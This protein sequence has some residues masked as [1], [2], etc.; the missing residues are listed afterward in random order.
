MPLVMRTEGLDLVV[1]HANQR[2]ANLTTLLDEVRANAF[3]LSPPPSKLR[4]DEDTYRRAMFIELWMMIAPEGRENEWRLFF[5]A[6]P[7]ILLT[8]S[9]VDDFVSKYYSETQ[10]QQSQGTHPEALDSLNASLEK[11]ALEKKRKRGERT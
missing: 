7:E 11:E 8:T 5:E 10:A 2:Q 1:A 4:H 6:N 3:L 9:S